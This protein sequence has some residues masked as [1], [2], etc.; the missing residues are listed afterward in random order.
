[1]S[2]LLKFAM[3]TTTSYPPLTSRGSISFGQDSFNYYP[4]GALR[5]N[6][7]KFHISGTLLHIR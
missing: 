3:R 1:M 4:C 6:V 5:R 7:T 2:S